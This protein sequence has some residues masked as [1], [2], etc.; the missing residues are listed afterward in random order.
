MKTMKKNFIY[1]VLLLMGMTMTFA[2]CDNYLNIEPKGKRIPKSLADYEAFLRYEYGVHRMPVTQANYLLNDQ[3]LT[4]SYAS[5]YPM[6][7]ANYNWDEE[8]DRAYWNNSDEGAYYVPYGAINTCNLILEDVPE[9]SDGTDKEKAEV[10]AYAKVLRAMNYFNLANY[11]ANTYE[12]SSAAAKLSVPLITSSLQ[13]APYHQ[14]TIQEIYEFIIKDLTEAVDD[15]PNMGTTILHPGK[16]AAYAMLARTYMQMM[17]YDR[18]L[19]YADKALA[20]N[21]ELV[22]W[23]NFYKENKSKI[24]QEGTYPSLATPLGVNSKDCYNFN[25]GESSYAST[26]SKMPVARAEG[27][28]DGDAYFLS[29]WKLRTLGSEIFYQ[30]LT[31]GNINYGGMRTVEQYLIKAECLARKGLLQDAMDVL[32]HV[33]QSYILPEKYQPLT[34]TIEAEAIG[35]IR[36]AK[37]NLLIF[38]IVPFVDARRYNAEGTYARTLTKEVDGKQ[39]SLSPTSHLWTF[40]FPQGALDNPGNGNFVQNVEK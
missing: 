22:D 23:V 31:N 12:A 17:D 15:L 40:P 39:V 19:D 3:Y 20:I 9:A 7:K 14:A 37:G 26:I 6:Y 4:N 35:Y 30:G 13:D 32:N 1:I 5:Y 2:S 28:E 18:A 11:Y 29:N 33:R 16:G 8:T 27:F 10:M 36:Q 25:Y 21:N 24:D 38:S 34:A